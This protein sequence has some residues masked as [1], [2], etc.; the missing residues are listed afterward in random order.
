M[1]R[2]ERLR[3]SACLTLTA[4]VVGCA[5]LDAWYGGGWFLDGP[6]Q[7]LGA[8]AM[9]YL[10]GAWLPTLPAAALVTG[11]AVGLTVANQRHEPGAYPVVD[12]LVFF[13][14]LV[15]APAVAGAAMARRRAQV[16]ELHRLGDRIAAQ[17]AADLEAARLEE[18]QR[19]EVEVHRRV[20]E[21]VGGLVLL[22]EGARRNPSPSAVLDALTRIEDAARATLVELREAVGTLRTT[23]EPLD[24]TAPVPDPAAARSAHTP[25][26]LRDVALAVGLGLSI[27]VETL[28][29]EFAR[30]PA[31]ANVLAALLVA[32][33][34]IWRRSRPLTAI[35][36]T[37]LLA[38][39]MTVLLTPLTLTVTALGLMLVATYSAGAYTRPWPLG[40]VLSWAGTTTLLVV[41]PA[42]YRDPD[43]W[44]PTLVLTTLVFV[45]G[46]VAAGAARRAAALR[47]HVAA[48]EDDRETARRAAVA[49]TRLS[50]ARGLHD[51]VAHAM[52][53]TCLQAAVARDRGAD[54]DAAL[55]TMLVAARECMADLRTGLDELDRASPAFDP[56]GLQRLA[57][58][59]GL[60]VEWHVDHAVATTAAAAPVQLVVREALTNAARHAPG[61]R[62]VVRVAVRDARGEDRVEIE[63]VDHGSELTTYDLGTGTG[64]IG[65]QEALAR[66]GGTLTAGPRRGGGFGVAASL[67]IRPEV[68][69]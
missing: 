64:L 4:V 67:P 5:L 63:V 59:A 58:E 48:L 49:G 27:A 33:P 10:L 26:D 13:L 23:P 8:L 20:I 25:P 41:T 36:T 22:A 2:R 40:L 28:V 50:L 1:T 7:V 53:V 60:D 15:G 31:W 66:Y 17:R 54:P 55:S 39:A 38:A 34:L 21:R 57:A 69:V 56:Q 12:D 9:G 52:T 61:S 3:R 42:G 44:A 19:V 6:W 32:T 37:W 11:S 30:G 68:P 47:A 29:R 18:R 43:A 46:V 16:T 45:A 51:S 65:L 24:A 14:L 35:G 62:V